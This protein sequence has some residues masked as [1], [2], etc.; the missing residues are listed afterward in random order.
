MHGP[1]IAGGERCLMPRPATDTP[2]VLGTKAVVP[3]SASNTKSPTLHASLLLGS[4]FT[5]SAA[6]PQ[7]A[8][9]L[10]P[11]KCTVAPLGGAALLKYVAIRLRLWPGNKVM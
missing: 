9:T 8:L 4:M 10:N 2:M 6:W 11:S 3:V 1:R 5:S 7:F